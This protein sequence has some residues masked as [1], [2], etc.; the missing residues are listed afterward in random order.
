MNFVKVN[1][2]AIL[3]MAFSMVIISCNGAHVDSEIE[4]APISK[5][6]FDLGYSAARQ[7][8]DDSLRLFSRQLSDDSLRL[9]YRNATTEEFVEF[10]LKSKIIPSQI[11]DA[12]SSTIKKV[13]E[14]GRKG[15]PVSEEYIEATVKNYETGLEELDWL[16]DEMK[17]GLVS[18]FRKKLNQARVPSSQSKF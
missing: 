4:K 14:L 1:L 11:D 6:E 15:T 10:L 7:L 17:E 5:D 16:S 13:T 9:F 12:T 18:R 2:T 3:P 8:S